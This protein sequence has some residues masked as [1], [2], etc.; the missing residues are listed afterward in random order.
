MLS[1]RSLWAGV[2]SSTA[3]DWTEHAQSLKRSAPW[4]RAHFDLL[5]RPS[6]DGKRQIPVDTDLLIKFIKDRIE[7]TVDEFA[8]VLYKGRQEER[9][10]RPAAQAKNEKRPP[11]VE[12]KALRAR[13]HFEKLGEIVNRNCGPKNHECVLAMRPKL[14][15]RKVFG[16]NIED[17]KIRRKICIY[18]KLELQELLLKNMLQNFSKLLFNQLPMYQIQLNCLVTDG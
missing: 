4:R 7:A 3:V 11:D 8:R 12:E 6:R 16:C 9:P 15:N 1:P 17:K 2:S 10:E 5:S 14:F 13:M 18:K